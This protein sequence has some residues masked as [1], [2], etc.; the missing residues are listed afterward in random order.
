MILNNLSSE[1]AAGSVQSRITATMMM[2][3]MRH[4]LTL[5]LCVL[6]NTCQLRCVSNN[7]CLCL[8]IMPTI[9]NP[10]QLT[11]LLHQH[12]PPNGN[13]HSF[14][15][16]VKY[17]LDW[18]INNEILTKSESTDITATSQRGK[19]LRF[20]LTL[21]NMASYQSLCSSSY[22]ESC[23]NPNTWNMSCAISEP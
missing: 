21:S 11:V 23:H 18:S 15:E 3:T 10:I 5:K 20:K 8:W 9:T 6:C 22:S 17:F 1:H 16:H 13:V 7:C 2:M 14:W 19:R 12:H 4:Y